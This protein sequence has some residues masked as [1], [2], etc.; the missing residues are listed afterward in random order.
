AE[1]AEIM[2]VDANGLELRASSYSVDR[3]ARAVTW[4]NPLVLQNEAGDPLTLPLASR[5][6]VELMTMCTE[7]QITG[8]LGFSSPLPWDLPAGEAYVSSAVTWGDLQ[9][10]VHA[11]FTQQT[12]ST[13][14]PNWTDLPIGN[15]TTAQYNSLAYP[16]IITNR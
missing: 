2:A 6:R 3:A 1:Q 14:A 4:A 9:S 11:W 7:V 16:P 5:G 8:E 10:R 15:T 12:W 13:G